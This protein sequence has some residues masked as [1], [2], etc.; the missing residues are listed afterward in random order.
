MNIQALKLELVGQILNT[1]SKAVLN[2]LRAILK[3]E[4]PDFW[5]ELSEQQKQEIALSRKQIQNGETE[6]WESLR[7]R[8]A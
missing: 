6:S 3:K 1:N 7:K 8:L 5:L 4:A 2:A